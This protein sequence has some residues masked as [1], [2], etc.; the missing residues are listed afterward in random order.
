M[1]EPVFSQATVLE[2]GAALKPWHHCPI[3]RGRSSCLETRRDGLGTGAS[4]HA[5]EPALIQTSKHYSNASAGQCRG[6]N[7]LL[8]LLLSVQRRTR[9]GSAPMPIALTSRCEG[10]LNR[11]AFAKLTL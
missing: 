9:S 8:G 3:A 7:F 5:G 6:L 1:R 4:Q 11:S 2:R 10:S